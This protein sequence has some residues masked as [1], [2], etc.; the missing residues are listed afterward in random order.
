MPYPQGVS[1]TCI[2]IADIG[3]HGGD[4]AKNVIYKVREPEVIDHDTSLPV[5]D[6]YKFTSV[7]VVIH[8]PPPPAPCP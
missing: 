1:G 2:Y 6:V 7:P 4:G 8:P 5:L 3:D